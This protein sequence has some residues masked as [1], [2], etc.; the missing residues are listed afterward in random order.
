MCGKCCEAIRVNVSPEEK[1]HNKYVNSRDWSFIGEHWRNISEDE[2]FHINPL[3][4]LQKE[5]GLIDHDVWYYA[6]DMYDKSTH[7]CMAHDDRPPVCSEYPYYGR[8]KPTETMTWYSA[9]CG[10][11]NDET[12]SPGERQL[13][14]AL[15][16]EILR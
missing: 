16:E 7:K 10:Y 9:T 8:I 12:V 11:I 4:R 5:V 6:C 3:L 15:A 2:A 1:E 14:I 13:M